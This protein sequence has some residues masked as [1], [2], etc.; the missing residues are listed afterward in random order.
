MLNIEVWK[1][2]PE[3]PY[4][5]SRSG[6]VRRKEGSAFK[7][8]NKDCVRPYLNNKG[9]SCINLWNKGKCYKYPVHRLIAQLYIP[10]PNNLP[11][12]NHIDGNP[13]NNAIDN[14]EWCTHQYNMQH[15][16]DTG[17]HINSDKPACAGIKY[18]TSTSK[19]HGVSWSEERQRWCAQ[20]HYKK[21]RYLAKR[22]KDEVE[23]A[24]AVDE[25]IKANG[26]EQ[27]G[28]KLNFN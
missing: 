9:Y 4:E 26:L 21:K 8:K 22:F 3:L 20:V 25:V 16:W 7:H 11:E 2:V 14:L 10:N 12:V 17:L 5:V 19:Y 18:S 28:Y 23:A 13:L 15:A 1:D 24:K 27:F 6:I